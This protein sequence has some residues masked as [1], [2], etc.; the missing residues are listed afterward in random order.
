MH[1]DV[2]CIDAVVAIEGLPLAVVT[3]SDVVYDEA[4]IEPLV[5][6]LSALCGKWRH[7]YPSLP[8]IV[9]CWPLPI[10]PRIIYDPVCVYV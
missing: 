6:T 7:L 3:A 9:S 5:K 4:Q 8:F 10:H 2:R 1:A